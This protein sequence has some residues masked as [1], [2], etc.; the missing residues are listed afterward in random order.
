VNLTDSRVAIKDS[1]AA[2]LENV[3]P[4]G[5]GALQ[6]L[7]G[8][9]PSIATLVQGIRSLWGFTLN[10]APVFIAVGNDGS[11]T[12]VTPGGV[13]TVIA[14][15]GTLGGD[16][17]VTIW[18][19]TTILILDPVTGYFSWDGAAFTVISATQ[20]GTAIAIFQGRAWL[21]NGRL[22]TF[23]APNTYNDFAAGNGAGSTILTDEAFPGN[24]VAAVS[25]LTPR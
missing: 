23:T 7:P 3:M 2:W 6:I 19:G 9:G 13:Q 24:I 25:A 4:V 12:Q 16:A 5:N 15:A 1:E 11:L 22:V 14:G 8:P 18:R 20:L 10:N 21:I 17:H